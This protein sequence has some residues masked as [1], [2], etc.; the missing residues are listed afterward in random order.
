MGGGAGGES[1]GLFERLKLHGYVTD[2]GSSETKHF[3][4][5]LCCISILTRNPFPSILLDL[6]AFLSQ[7]SS[8]QTFTYLRHTHMHDRQRHV[9]RGFHKQE[10]DK[11]C[12]LP[13]AGNEQLGKTLTLESK[14]QYTNC[15]QSG[16][17]SV[18]VIKRLKEKRREE[19][20][21]TKRHPTQVYL[22]HTTFLFFFYFPSL[23][24][25]Q[26]H[27]LTSCHSTLFK[28]A[29]K[30]NLIPVSAFEPCLP[31]VAKWKLYC[32]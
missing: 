27:P 10:V 16:S 18:S 31:S 13:K 6:Q 23:D 25:A 7:I 5:K 8:C 17:K 29:T 32:P 20:T 14:A 30:K 4:S 26:T 28:H 2:M 24:F 21:T 11:T 1:G 19:Q 3:Q 22:S 12:L 15:R 9:C